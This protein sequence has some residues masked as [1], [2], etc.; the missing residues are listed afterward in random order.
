MRRLFGSH[1]LLWLDCLQKVEEGKIKRLMGLMPPGSAKALALDTPIPTPDGWKQMGELCVGD[2]VFDERGQ[3]CNVTWVSPIWRH[4]PCYEVTTDCGDKIVADQDHEWLVHL[5]RKPGRGPSIKET[6]ELASHRS[7]G[8]HGKLLSKPRAKRPMIER[9]TA[10]VLPEISLPLDPYVLGVWLG[11]GT[12]VEP[13]ISCGSQDIEWLLGEL[14]RLRMQVSVLDVQENFRI[15]LLGVRHIF[16]SLGLLG[17]NPVMRSQWG[18]K[19]VPEMYM[20][21]SVKQ[22]LSL[23][24]GL[25]DTDGTVNKSGMVIFTNTN[26]GLVQAVAELARTLGVKASITGPRTPILNGVTCAPYWR[27]S[28]YLKGAARLPRKAKLCRNQKRTPNAYIEVKPCASTDTVCIEV[29]SPSHLFLCGKSL[30]PTHN[31]TYTSV[32]FPTHFMGRFPG[33]NIIVASYGSDLP[34]KFGRRARSIVKQQVFHRIFNTQLAED[35]KAAD[36]WALANSSEWMAA[37]ILTGITGNRADGVIWDDLI[38]G[39]EQADSDVVRNKTWDAYFDDLLTRK[40]PSSWEVGITTRWHEDDVAGR[41]LP[42]DYNGESGPIQCRDGNEWYVV[43]LQAEAERDDDILGRKVGEILWPEWFTPQ[44]FAPFKRN[45]R[46][47]SALYQQR[48][49]PETGDFFDASWFKT[50]DAQENGLP[51]DP[52]VAGRKMSRDEFSV[53]GA[54]DYAVSDGHGDYTVHVV[55]GID[56][57]HNM[58]LLDLWRGQ[59]TSHDWVER[60]L[61]MVQRWNPLGWAEESGQIRSS[62]D[63]LIRKRMQERIAYVVRAQF[64]PRVNKKIR[65]QSIRGRMQDKGLFCPAGAPWYPEF[66]RELLL[67]DAGKND[68]Q[69]D[70]ISLIGQVLDRMI[71]ADP[72]PAEEDKP[73]VM[74]TDP[75]LCTVTLDDLFEANEDRRHRGVIRIS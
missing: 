52:K 46:T 43:C 73:K 13:S 40:K 54:S 17:G 12:T 3:P 22:R 64:P 18:N 33:S 58:Y 28:F 69:V 59:K 37:G 63:P 9:A 65:A 36:E 23:L 6:R 29:D 20:R 39:R 11:D 47:W 72:A 61:D 53:Y 71:A 21:A 62:M 56:K 1:H 5:C 38:K 74:S 57:Y 49:A 8:R 19:F 42:P 10:I 34:R 31:S 67:F 7:Y 41:I 4:R 32:V 15:R 68:D 16:R 48:P 75:A 2:Q 50:F 55:V 30:L 35:S 44:H 66:R 60:M 26:L 45:A 51:F 14:K 27:V 70:A 24:Q 25:I